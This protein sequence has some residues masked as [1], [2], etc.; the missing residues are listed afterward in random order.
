VGADVSEAERPPEAYASVGEF[1][2]RDL[3]PGLRRWPADPHQPGSPADGI[4]GAHGRIEEGTALQAK[5]ID[6]RIADL[7][8]SAEAGERFTGGVFLT[9]Y[10]APRHYHRVHVPLTA[11]LSWAHRIPGRLFPVNA[12]AVSSVRDLLVRNERL[13]TV[14]EGELLEVAVVA[15]GALNVGSI[16]ADFEAAPGARQE[17][18]KGALGE[19]SRAPVVRAYDPPLRLEA[20]DPL[21]TFHLGSTVVLLA[22]G[23][24]GHPADLHP[25]LRAGAEIRVGQPLL[26]TRAPGR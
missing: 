19:R 17:A 4:V 13:V 2:V 23:R 14:L 8:G 12:P 26:A 15:V 24:S 9:I 10:L 16:S 21:M 5:G 6:Y 22:R 11:S 20:G 3:T 18:S 1:F 7:L 25:D